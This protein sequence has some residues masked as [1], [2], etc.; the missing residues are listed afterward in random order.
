MQFRV[1]FCGG[2]GMMLGGCSMDPI[3]AKQQQQ[4]IGSHKKFTKVI[5]Y[6][7]PIETDW[8]ALEQKDTWPTQ[9]FFVVSL[10]L[11]LIFISAI[12]LSI[13]GTL[14]ILTIWQAKVC[15]I[16]TPYLRLSTLWG[17]CV[18]CSSMVWPLKTPFQNVSPFFSMKIKKQEAGIYAVEMCNPILRCSLC[19][20]FLFFLCWFSFLSLIP[21]PLFLSIA[22][23]LSRRFLQLDASCTHKLFGQRKKS[24]PTNG[25]TTIATTTTKK[26]NEKQITGFL[27]NCFA[28][29]MPNSLSLDNCF[30][31]CVFFSVVSISC[32]RLNK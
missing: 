9:F 3:N 15:W 26:W 21:L 19:A 28:F 13:S 16:F 24:E 31:L 6:S 29:V 12:D 22:R 4:Q 27:L 1:F 2:W 10:C 32:V 5:R 17:C 11:M 25:T 23:S 8:L 18:P 14:S 7:K 20:I 30:T